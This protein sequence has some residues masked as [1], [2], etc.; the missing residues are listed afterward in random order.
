MFKW[1]R[2]M[3]IGSKI[4][5][6]Y[7]GFFS[8]IMIILSIFIMCNTLYFYIDISKKELDE[9]VNKVAEYIKAGGPIEDENIQQ[10]NPNNLFEIKVIKEKEMKHYFNGLMNDKK[11]EDFPPPKIDSKPN[12]EF[13]MDTIK[14]KK[15]MSV[16]KVVGVDG[17]NYVIQIFRPYSQE[18]K[19]SRI[20]MIIF[21]VSNIIGIFIAFLIG[22]FISKKLLKPI[23]D[24]S[25]TAKTISINDL[26]QRITVPE[27]NDEIRNLVLTFNDMIS[28]LEISVGKQ[29]QFIS[30]ASHELRTPISVIKGYADLIDRWG[31]TDTEILQESIESIKSETEHMNN[32]IKKLLFLARTEQN[33]VIQYVEICINSVFEDIV[34]EVRLIHNDIEINVF[35]NEKLYIEG[36]LDMIKQTIWIFIDNAIKYSN[37][38]NKKINIR[39]YKDD[40]YNIFEIEDNGIGINKEDIPYIFDRFYRGDKSRS[41][42]TPGT[43]LGLSIAQKIIECHKGYVNAE[44]DIGKG[45]KFIVLFPITNIVK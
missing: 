14:G 13:E 36:D 31:K 30:D 38:N 37:K 32:L 20:I 2:K 24:I 35:E 25:N 23:V 39:I 5:L 22:R 15:Y 16:Q 41:K 17:E 7:A 27:P 33:I 42:E 21:I 34:K 6:L 10:F 1:F 12:N 45:T 8:L 26:T 4:T 29:K 18:Q 44:S 43:G 40:K 3:P 19:I 11:K 9:T 28:R